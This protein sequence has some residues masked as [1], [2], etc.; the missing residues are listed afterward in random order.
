MFFIAVLV[1]RR[2]LDIGFLVDS[3]PDISDDN[4]QNILAFMKNVI[5]GLQD[6]S[7]LA[8]GARI[9]IISHASV[10]YMHNDFNFLWGPTI[11]TFYTTPCS[12]LA[13]QVLSC[14]KCMS[15]RISFK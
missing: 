2:A 15:R 12:I 4:W 6:F 10:P 5:D 11:H 3:A 14:R 1:K 7:P 8:P 13:A 9:G